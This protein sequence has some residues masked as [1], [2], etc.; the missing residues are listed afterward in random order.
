MWVGVC[1]LL[2]GDVGIGFCGYLGNDVGMGNSVGFLRGW[3][4]YRWN[5]HYMENQRKNRPSYNTYDTF[6]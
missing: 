1:A 6:E 4:L 3:A 2:L 5:V